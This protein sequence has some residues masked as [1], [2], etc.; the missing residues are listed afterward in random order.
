[1]T[2]P[3][4]SPTPVHAHGNAHWVVIG[5]G[6]VGA[7]IAYELSRHPGFS[8]T[9][10][11]RRSNRLGHPARRMTQ[12]RAFA[13][14]PL[15]ESIHNPARLPQEGDASSTSAAL[16][17]MTG[18][19]SRKTQGRAWALRVASLER[20][21]TLIP[22]LE[23]MTGETLRR[24]PHGLLKLIEADEDWDSW[25][26]LA[27]ERRSQGYSLDC[28]SVEA[29]LERV[30]G[31]AG[32][33]A[34]GAVHSPQDGQIDPIHLTNLLVQAA[35]QNG[36]QFRWTTQV[37]GAIGSPRITRLL[38]TAGEIPCDGVI[39]AA[40]VG[41]TPFTEAIASPLPLTAVLGQAC[42]VCHPAAS[43]PAETQDLPTQDL[44]TQNLPTQNLPTQDL[45][46]QDLPAT[47]GVNP[48]L[49]PPE[50]PVLTRRDRWVVPL[51]ADAQSREHYWLGS[52]VEFPEGAAPPVPN[53]AEFATAIRGSIALY[54]ALAD[55]QEV[56]RWW[57]C[58]PRPVGRG[59]PVIT[60]LPNYDNV[61]AATGHYRNG[62]LLAPVTGLQ[63]VDWAEQVH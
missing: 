14:A 22:E 19:I 3:I 55:A 12:R 27:A 2:S 41:S 11:D 20:Y 44:P 28:W 21:R 34:I 13:P 61:L 26:E 47:D 1:M 32:A 15:S 23:A 37:T 53:P 8:I 7:A 58:R 39:V 63:A 5:S 30:P 48:A 42:Q 6:V 45:P 57:G 54:P 59:A 62:V 51:G 38:T 17:V 18:V 36:V 35:E 4:S 31:L 9:V 49:H 52:T 40:G 60:P 56:R 16:G 24:N 10:V 25:Q 43:L 50:I 29:A 33:G 46:S